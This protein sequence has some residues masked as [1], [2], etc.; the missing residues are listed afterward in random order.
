MAT[1][2]TPSPVWIETL[3]IDG[4]TR[5]TSIYAYASSDSPHTLPTHADLMPGIGYIDASK[6]D[7]LTAAIDREVT[8]GT[9]R[10]IDIA[11]ASEA[12]LVALIGRSIDHRALLKLVEATSSATVR[13][14]AR[15]RIEYVQ[16]QPLGWLLHNPQGRAA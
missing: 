3:P 12:D 1:K 14:A 7:A 15:A 11:K 13:E 8:R 9:M 16:A 6:V 2:S 4:S 10:L 5:P